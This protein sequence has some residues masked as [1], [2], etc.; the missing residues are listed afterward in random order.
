MAD[1][2]SREGEERK[3]RHKGAEHSNPPEHSASSEEVKLGYAPTLLGDTRLA[4]ANAPMRAD[5]VQR[6][7]QTHGNRSV[8]RFLAAQRMEAAIEGEEDDVIA[9]RIEAKAGGGNGLDTHLQRKLESG[10]GAD[11]SG[12]RVHTDA[13]AD[14]L[15]R[16]VQSV[17]FTTGQDIFFRSGAYNPESPEGLRLLA[18]EATHTVQQSVGPVAGTPSAGG[19]S[20]SDPS[21][22][23]EQEAEAAAE[24]VLSGGERPRRLEEEM[25]TPLQRSA[26]QRSLAVQ[27]FPFPFPFHNPMPMP[28]F[29][30]G[31]GG[32]GGGGG[33]FYNPM[34]MPSFPGGGFGGGGFGGGGGG[35]F[36]NPT[37]NIPLPLH[38]MPGGGTGMGWEPPKKGEA[39]GPW[40]YIKDNG[41]KGWDQ[42]IEGGFGAFHGEGDILGV[43]VVDD[44]LYAQGKLGAWDNGSGGM[45]HGAQGSAGAGKLQIN[46]GGKVSGDMEAFTASA[47]ASIGDDGATLGAQATLVGGSMTL[48]NFGNKNAAGKNLTNEST[49]RLGLSE[50]VGAAGRLHWG[51]TDK[52]GQRE[53][54]FGFDAGPVSMDLKTEDPARLALASVLGGV[55]GPGGIYAVDKGLEWL[56]GDMNYTDKAISGAKSLYNAG[57]KAIDTIGEYGN[58][59]YEGAGEMWDSAKKYGSGMYDAAGKGLSS[60]YDTVSSGLGSAYTAAGKGLNS[61]YDTVSSGL[62]SAY[63]YAGK[64]LNSAYD[65]VGSGLNSA[66]G[67]VSDYGGR[68]YD[69][70]GDAASGA[71][72]TVSGGLSSA[73]DWLLDW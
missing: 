55:A 68:A 13:E 25:A 33:P 50:G 11:M 51:D 4:G 35:P 48:G 14:T 57:S 54:G 27:R 18:H 59:A 40:A 10:L 38:P 20:I 60:A 8:Q 16:S 7:Q 41:K 69:A 2:Q 66:Y 37:P 42:G 70:V 56:G 73:K 47:E 22:S 17:A 1:N 21:D 9:R 29:P 3:L 46:N 34:P 6:A 44:L 12:V 49:M 39:P 23:F 58:K 67:T 52:D 65:A 36:Y 61:A 71:Y 28:S 64:G 43:P 19:V 26:V 53:Y 24:A 45:R 15:A 30:S 63:D 62:G 72:D 31:F 5:I 32:F